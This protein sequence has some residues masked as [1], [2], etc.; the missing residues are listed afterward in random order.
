MELWDTLKGVVI[1]QWSK[2]KKQ[3]ENHFCDE[4]K[5]RITLFST[6][7]KNG[8]SPSRGRAA[9]LLD[10]N[11]IYEANTD[12]WLM[13]EINSHNQSSCKVIERYEFHKLL[14]EY[15]SQ[16]IERSLLSKYELIRGLAIIDKRV[17]KRRLIQMKEI[18]SE[19][20]K[21]LYQLRCDIEGIRT[22]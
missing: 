1:I 18:E 3:V 14:E 8:G 5:D 19:F 17:G 2:L 9:V 10:K 6:W 21:K 20:C 15:L 11:E 22:I 12:K 4:L 7:Y 13:S 16:S